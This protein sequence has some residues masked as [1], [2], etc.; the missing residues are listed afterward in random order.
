VLRD[1]LDSELASL[2]ARFEG[3]PNH[4]GDF[5]N[6]FRNGL[7]GDKSFFKHFL[8]RMHYNTL[9]AESLEEPDLVTKFK[10]IDE[11]T[12]TDLEAYCESWGVGW[13][14]RA[15]T[16]LASLEG[17]LP[18]FR[19][20]LER[21]DCDVSPSDEVNGSGLTPLIDAS[22]LG[23]VSM[24]R[25]ILE[26][27][28]EAHVNHRSNTTQVSALGDAALRGHAQVVRLLLQH[29]AL[30]DV[31]RTDGKTP[32]HCAAE[33]GHSQCVALLLEAGA[34][35]LAR[36]QNGHQ[37]ADLVEEWQTDVR[38]QFDRTLAKMSS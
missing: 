37:P 36:D 13:P 1:L 7:Q 38:Q 8:L 17:N 23:C 30:V 9:L 24:V 6:R 4:R 35:P 3:D 19:Y 33:Q 29:R 12:V 16:G 21:S 26:R 2:R 34:C 15:V 22:R 27:V 14:E 32:L 18:I 5:W 25:Y 20:A 11:M 10:S 31:Q 28:D